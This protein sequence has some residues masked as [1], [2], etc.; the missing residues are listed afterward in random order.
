MQSPVLKGISM[1]RNLKLAQKLAL[2]L[3]FIVALSAGAI[4]YGLHQ[5]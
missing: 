1:F 2:G 5:I 3:G 4:A